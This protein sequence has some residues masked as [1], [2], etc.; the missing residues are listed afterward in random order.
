MVLNPKDGYSWL[1]LNS[2]WKSEN[3]KG[4]RRI[5]IFLP[6]KGYEEKVAFQIDYL[7]DLNIILL[8]Y[9]E[10]GLLKSSSV[11]KAH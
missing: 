9:L 6:C 5:V 3:I 4:I 10:K 2:F 8:L 11:F 1:E 7:F